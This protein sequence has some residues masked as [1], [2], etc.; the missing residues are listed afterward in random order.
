[1][2]LVLDAYPGNLK[3]GDQGLHAL[4]KPCWLL[5]LMLM[6]LQHQILA[7]NSFAKKLWS[8]VECADL[9]RW[10]FC[11]MH[12]SITSDMLHQLYQGVVKHMVDWC[13]SFM[14]KAEFD[15]RV[16]ALPLCFGL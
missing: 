15:F 8:L 1:M 9:S 16:H 7:S 5:Y 3:I 4:S 14:D 11:G 13:S 12:L 10:D 2:G 6:T